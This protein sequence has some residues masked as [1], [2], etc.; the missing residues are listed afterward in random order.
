MILILAEEDDCLVHYVENETA[1][2][3]R[4]EDILEFIKKRADICFI[5]FGA[6]CSVF[7]IGHFTREL[8]SLEKY[9]QE[10]PSTTFYF[11]LI[12]HS[13][14]YDE[15]EEIWELPNVKK[16]THSEWAIKGD[17]IKRIISGTYTE[18]TREE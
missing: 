1:D 8:I 11:C 12:M 16:V 15:Y 3:Y 14:F 18:L 6:V 2:F 17:A 5:D 13:D 7:D 4:T 9:I 10:N